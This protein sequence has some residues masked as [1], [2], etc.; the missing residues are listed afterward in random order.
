MVRETN[1]QSNGGMFVDRYFQ[2]DAFEFFRI[3]IKIKEPYKM[4]SC[5]QTFVHAGK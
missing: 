2:F 4:L 5:L 1:A 3:I